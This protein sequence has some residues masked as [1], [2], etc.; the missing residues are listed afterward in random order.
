MGDGGTG[1]RE[2]T[3]G[4]PPH[5]KYLLAIVF[6]CS[7]RVG[8]AN[9]LSFSD[10]RH[11]IVEFLEL[12]CGNCRRGFDKGAIAYVLET[13]FVSKTKLGSHRLAPGKSGL[14][15]TERSALTTSGGRLV[16]I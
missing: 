6:H 14:P 1:G 15:A 8:R 7:D 12:S 10:T 13:L 2:E 4:D 9:C 16:R 3:S 5:T 11:V